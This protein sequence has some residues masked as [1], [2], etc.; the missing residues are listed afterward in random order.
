MIQTYTKGTQLVLVRNPNWSAASDS[1]RPAYPDKIVVKFGLDTAVIDQRLIADA[2]AD[3]T[4][5]TAGDV[6]DPASLANVF[7]DP[8]FANRRVN[9][10]DPYSRYYAINTKTVPNLKQRQALVVAI[11][12]AEL[13][14]I[15][16]GSYAGDL[17]DGAIKPTLAK[18]YE[19]T[20]VYDPG[21]YGQKVPDTGDP[22]FAKKLIKESGAPMKTLRL[23][24]AQTPTK[25]KF[26]AAIVSSAKLAGITIK[27]NPIE[28]G[29]YYSIVQDPKKAGDIID[30]GWGPDWANAS[31][32]IPEL[33]TPSGGFNLSEA[34][35]AAFN[36]KV[37]DA[38]GMTNR[39]DQAK[40]W[41]ALNKESMQNAWL[42]PRLFGRQQRL[43]GSKIGMAS[44]KDGNPYF[45]APYGSWPYAE[46]FVRS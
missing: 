32:V 7:K 21:L 19:P 3:Q 38:K 18:D 26:A 15:A 14:T 42:I 25:D 35:D 29:I 36:K 24:Y 23:D 16:G 1:Y 44:G 45:W 39:D 20:G 13:R 37:D 10:F 22:E 4:A 6:V 41:K 28:R 2:A 8:R 30:G 33:F 9:D 43:A 17:G 11:N 5:L 40:A 27:P 34:N 12:R 46:L 31:T